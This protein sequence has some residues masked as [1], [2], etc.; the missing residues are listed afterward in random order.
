MAT[1]LILIVDDEPTSIEVLYR[2]LSGLGDLRFATSGS[3]ALRLLA[4]YPIDLILLDLMMPDM[5][6]FSTCSLIKAEFPDT[7]IIFV[8]AADNIDNEVHALEVGGIDFIHKPIS[9]PVVKARVTTHLKLKAQGDLLRELSK[10]DPLTGIANRRA[11]DERIGLE[12]RRAQRSGESLSLLMIDIDYFKKYNDHYGHL[13]GDD[14]LR[15]I[16]QAIEGVA[17]RASD[18]SARF[19]GEEFAVLLGNTDADQAMVVANRLCARVRALQIPHAPTLSTEWVTVSVGVGSLCPQT[20]NAPSRSSMASKAEEGMFA[21]R[22]LFALADRALYAAK[23]AG[24]DRIEL[25]TKPEP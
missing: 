1:P 3:D 7:P 15:K 13:E 22:E 9:P 21:A 16:A 24:R 2:A 11:L 4:E 6:G 5:D 25:T 20:V 23:E 14:C 19:G 18:L 8:T 10:H 17:T 12:W